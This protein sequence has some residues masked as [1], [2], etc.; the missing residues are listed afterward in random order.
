MMSLP[1]ILRLAV[2]L[3][4][5][6][7]PWDPQPAPVGWSALKADWSLTIR[8]GEPVGVRATYTLQSPD[9]RGEIVTLVGPELLIT[10]VDG[11]VFSDERGLNLA[12]GPDQTAL[13]QSFSGLYSPESDG[14]MQ[15]RALPATRTHITVDAPGLDVTL[16]GAVDGWLSPTDTLSIAWRPHVED[17]TRVEAALVQGEAASVFRA[18]GNALLVES[19][20]RW[21]VVRGEARRLSFA[22]NGLEDLEVTGPGVASWRREGG[23]VLI[24]PKAPVKGL[25]AVTVRGRTPLGAG[26]RS[27]PTPE[28]TAY[29]GAAVQRVDTFVTM[30]R[31]EGC[32]LI[33]VAAPSSVALGKL[34][35]WAKNLGDGVPLVAW[36]G[37]RPVRVLRASYE[38]VQGPDTV[39]TQARFT[40]AAAREGRAAL[41]MNLRVRNERR[42]YLHLRPAKGWQPVVV[43][44]GNQ[45]VSWLSDGEGGLYVPLEKSIET[46]KG[47]LSFPVDVEWLG[48]DLLPWERRGEMALELPSLDAPV[49]SATWEVH[50][51]RGFRALRPPLKGSAR[52]M[53]TDLRD[54]EDQSGEAQAER[55]RQE[56][57]SSAIQN[58]VNAYKKNDWSG[59]QL[60]LDEVK[61]VDDGNEDAQSL[62]ANLDILEGRSAQNDMGSR[63]VKD[64]AKAKTSSMHAN[65]KSVEDEANYA[66]LAGDLDKAEAQFEQ[67]LSVANELQKTE[68][69][70]SVEQSEKISDALRKLAE[71]RQQKGQRGESSRQS[72]FGSDGDGA[73]GRGK[74]G[75]QEEVDRGGFGGVAGGL[76]G[77][78]LAGVASDESPEMVDEVTGTFSAE[79][80]LSNRFNFESATEE[81]SEADEEIVNSN[82]Y[83]DAPTT[84]MPAA[85]SRSKSEEKKVAKRSAPP[86]AQAPAMRLAKAW[87]EPEPL[88]PPTPLASV[89]ATPEYGG[90]MMV[91]RSYQSAVGMAAG[92]V[93]HEPPVFNPY[94][95]QNGAKYRPNGPL[96]GDV[97]AGEDLVPPTTAYAPP[98]PPPAPARDDTLDRE[99][100]ASAEADRPRPAP[101]RRTPLVASA[102][103]LAL[104]MPLD[105]PTLTTT[106]ALLPAGS[107]PRFAFLYKETHAEN[108]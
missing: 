13:T 42:Q 107:P 75:E 40:L 68:Q 77:G 65:Q 8:A 106:Q 33:P 23:Q 7:S 10:E 21:R 59:A 26:E 101:E 85:K 63:R 15:L 53:V 89:R 70:E 61:S 20:L 81:E 43:R 45:P 28:P 3:A 1:L 29:A 94:A 41:R 2:G 56:V 62:Q 35:I 105:G 49:Q 46:V 6:A 55:N 79:F 25:F 44:V 72:S 39:V 84:R 76:V 24:E 60:W 30:A 108:P 14:E 36:H 9:A 103:P 66:Y 47:L 12:L 58:A 88:P 54:A 64:L 22:T 82:G 32:E 83:M 73:S 48:T 90:E 31:S 74:V 86:P 16:N 95:G 93:A 69:L 52:M 67:A 87:A 11:A 4:S 5:A 78:S 34:P 57:V 96:P 80:N 71:I 37:P 38:A 17:E 50:L 92:V 104:A 91:G 97:S 27:V 100:A 98:P 51:P 99:R 102:A 18:D 19:Q